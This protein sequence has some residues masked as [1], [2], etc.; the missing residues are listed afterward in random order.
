MM[1]TSSTKFA[2]IER[3]IA[4]AYGVVV[5]VLVV[6]LIASSL[7]SAYNVLYYFNPLM[8][9]NQAAYSLNGVPQG[10]VELPHEVDGLDPG[11]VVSVYLYS[12]GNEQDSLLVEAN[13][14]TCELFV[15]GESFYRV[16]EEG[17]YP[18]FQ[19]E[20]PR[21]LKIV[22]LPNVGAGTELRLDYTIS[23]IGDSLRL[24]PYYSGD[25][26]LIS[27]NVFRE[28]YLALALSL[29]TVMAGVTLALIGLVFLSR[30]ELAGALFWLGFSCL[31][32]G[33]WTFFSNDVVLMS[34]NQFS[35]FYTVS[36]VS[37]LLLP[38]PLG[39]F[40]IN[41]LLPY[42]STVLNVAYAIL[43][44]LFLVQ[45]ALHFSGV[46]SLGQAEPYLRISGS[47]LLVAYIIFILVVRR[48]LGSNVSPPFIFGIALFAGL[49][50]FDVLSGYMG[51]HSPTGT[52]F[53]VGL[54]FATIVI[55]LIVWE[56]LSK[57]LDAM[58][59]NTRLEADISAINLSLDLQR[60]HFQDFT[61]SEEQLRRMRH[62]LRHQLVAIKGFIVENKDSE[63]LEY[64]DNISATIPSI[65][66]KMICDNIAVNS[67]A[68]YYIAKAE[69]EHIFCDVKMAVPATLGSVPDG[70][71]SIIFGNLFE[72]AI[73]ACMHVEPEKRFIKIRA[74]VVSNR[75]TLTIDNSYDGK[76]H[77]SGKD[78]YSRKREGFGVGIASVRSVISKYQGS[79][80]YETDSGV[81]KTSLY[82]RI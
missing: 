31:I 37:L 45:M 68:V 10:M 36:L 75:F 77:V 79:M 57:A 19:K 67:L 76:L 27:K 69:A 82:V 56:F 8:V 72:N 65:S 30:L 73:E 41:F 55:T 1:T 44:C 34:F 12:S 20:P 7:S 64:I 51:I 62:D 71:L 5:V 28:N 49:S 11:D 47:L 42:R 21:S 16:G 50:L 14:V 33:C 22:A 6:V 4:A 17:S 53:M 63:A 74:N 9:T 78:F 32:C 23:S 18:E 48:K 66:E 81:F 25:Q 59:K 15:G 3:V 46:F 2:V 61:K 29:L 39:R 38:L 26:G 80:K 58:E 54:F 35:V 40:C 24:T 52:F 43:C 13:R 70:D 60:K